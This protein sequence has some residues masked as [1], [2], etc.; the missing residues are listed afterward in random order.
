MEKIAVCGCCVSRDTIAF[1]ESK[2]IQ[3]GCFIHFNS[4]LS[5]ACDNVLDDLAVKQDDLINCSPFLK[6]VFHADWF[7]ESFSLLKSANCKWCVID[8]GHIRY[9]LGEITRK[10]DNAKSY[11]TFS[12]EASENIEKVLLPAL[13]DRYSFQKKPILELS[14]PELRRL[15]ESYCEK[16]LEIYS[17]ENIILQEISLC[18]LYKDANGGI[19]V[20]EHSFYKVNNFINKCH[21][22]IRSKIPECKVIPFPQYV[23]C[24]EEHVWGSYCLHYEQLYYKYA[25]ECLEK[26]I[27]NGFTNDNIHD[28]CDKY[29]EIFNEKFRSSV[30]HGY[31]KQKLVDDINNMIMP[32]AAVEKSIE[33][34]GISGSSY[35]NRET[36]ELCVRGWYL[37]VDAYDRIVI[38]ADGQYIGEAKIGVERCDVELNNRF[39]K[40]SRNSGFEISAI[41]PTIQKIDNITVTAVKSDKM[42]KQQDYRVK[43]I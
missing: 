15:L 40:N 25:Y 20:F 41:V 43:N 35:F 26:I 32:V 21:R 8:I 14:D 16:L 36:H 27:E 24:D 2:N 38:K 39:Y 12:R 22:I 9:D 23:L 34:G 30:S 28:L 17:P 29:C 33:K 6:R 31:M 5:L 4:P 11:I 37:P 7:K 1:A 10:S 18:E 19:N 42:V 13:G 3:T